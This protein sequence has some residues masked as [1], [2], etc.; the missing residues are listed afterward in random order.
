M[1]LFIYKDLFQTGEKEVP[2]TGVQPASHTRGIRFFPGVKRPPTPSKAEF[3]ER[4]ELYLCSPWDKVVCY[5]V[6]FTCKFTFSYAVITLHDPQQN[7]CSCLCA[8]LK[9]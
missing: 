8:L 5:R 7:F 1:M 9:D 2:H 3:K 4:V 6:N